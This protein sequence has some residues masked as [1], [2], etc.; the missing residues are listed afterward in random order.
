MINYLFGSL[1]MVSL[2]ISV[3][4]YYFYF[5]S[6]F[7]LFWG[8]FSRRCCCC[9][10][11]WALTFDGDTHNRFNFDFCSFRCDENFAIS[12]SKITANA[13]AVSYLTFLLRSMVHLISQ[14]FP[15]R[16]T[17]N[18]HFIFLDANSRFSARTVLL[19]SFACNWLHLFVWYVF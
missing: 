8:Y 10:C 14:W 16:C 17:I 18:F 6:V 19:F 11:C 4:V 1:N 9:C 15:H 3:F 12:Q 13:S 5:F 2:E 7:V